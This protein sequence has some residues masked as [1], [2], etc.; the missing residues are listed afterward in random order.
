MTGRGVGGDT[1]LEEANSRRKVKREGV[2]GMSCEGSPLGKGSGV[3]ARP[4]VTEVNAFRKFHSMAV[5][6]GGHD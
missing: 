2:A 5:W 3:C 4:E 6:C 1:I